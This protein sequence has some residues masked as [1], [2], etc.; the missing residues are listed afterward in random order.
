MVTSPCG[1]SPNVTTLAVVFATTDVVRSIVLVWSP[2]YL[3]LAARPAS[4]E[5]GAIIT[6]RRM[7]MA[8]AWWI[9][10]FPWAGRGCDQR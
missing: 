1:T 3:G 2:S 5:W 8:S 7:F 10:L 6:E 4:S 9:S